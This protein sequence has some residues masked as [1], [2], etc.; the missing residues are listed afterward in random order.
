MINLVL[1]VGVVGDLVDNGC[2]S[3]LMRYPSACL[4]FFCLG[5][6]LRADVVPA[7][8]FQ[9]HAVLQQGRPIPVW[10]TAVAGEKVTVTYLYRHDL[11]HGHG[12]HRLRRALAR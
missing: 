1:G 11:A 10:G 9:D 3:W 2:T 5:T 8:P 4:I 7:F 12:C 6:A